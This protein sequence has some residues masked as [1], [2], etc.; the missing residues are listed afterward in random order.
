MT[1]IEAMSVEAPRRQFNSSRTAQGVAIAALCKLFPGLIGDVLT[2]QHR[3]EVWNL[4][5]SVPGADRFGDSLG[6]RLVSSSILRA[7]GAR[8]A[9]VIWGRLPAETEAA[10]QALG[11]G[12]CCRNP[13]ESVVSSYLLRGQRFAA[14]LDDDCSVVLWDERKSR[15]ILV[16]QPGSTEEL[17]TDSLDGHRGSTTD[18]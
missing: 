2:T 3:L 14:Y 16:N 5:R 12:N 1:A 9:A 8:V 10:L 13:A 15:L 18:A 11:F 17:R 7:D 4:G 6:S